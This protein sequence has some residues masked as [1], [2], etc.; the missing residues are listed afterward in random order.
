MLSVPQPTRKQPESPPKP[1]CRTGQ[2][3]PEYACA[4]ALIA[5]VSIAALQMFGQTIFNFLMSFA[6]QFS[7]V[8]GGV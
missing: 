8:V 2:T 4:I 1:A 7:S 6:S 5:I 3:L